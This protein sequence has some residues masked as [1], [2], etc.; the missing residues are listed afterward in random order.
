ME[1]AEDQIPEKAKGK[2]KG[3]PRNVKQD[4]ELRV[5]TRKRPTPKV[6][7]SGTGSTAKPASKGGKARLVESPDGDSRSADSAEDEPDAREPQARESAGPSKAP[8][9]QPRHIG[10]TAK[11][12]KLTNNPERSQFKYLRSLSLRSEYQE[13]VEVVYAAPVSQVRERRMVTH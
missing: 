1:T 11:A 4:V 9:A 2:G 13:L 6:R 7:G 3:K 10:P 8:H 5:S 12:T